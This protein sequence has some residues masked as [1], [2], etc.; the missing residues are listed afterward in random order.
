MELNLYLD[1]IN[2]ILGLLILVML[3]FIAYFMIKELDIVRSIIFLKGDKLK[4]PTLII[5]FGIILFVIR[6][7]YTATKSIGIST[8]AILEELLELGSVLMIFLGIL[9]V[10]RLFISRIP[11]YK[12]SKKMIK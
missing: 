10:F 12:F 11:I 2:A 9:I 6:E 8:S 5:S 7:T 3:G 1:V 4:N